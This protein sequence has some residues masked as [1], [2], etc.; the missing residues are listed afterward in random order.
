MVG[1]RVTTGGGG[2]TALVD[3]DGSITYAEL[4]RAVR[5]YA[6]RLDRA[7]VPAG[8]CGLVVADDAIATVVAVLALWWRG[9]VAV[10]VSSMLTPA[11]VSFIAGDCAAGYLHLDDRAARA[12]PAAG[13]LDVPRGGPDRAGPAP[14]E[15]GTP[16]DGTPGEDLA[17]AA[18]QAPADVVLIQYTSGSTGVPKGVR[19]TV[20]GIDAVLAGFAR[21]LDLTPADRV[22]STAKLSFGYGF[23]NS[24]LFPLAAG[25]SAVLRPGPPDVYGVVATVARHRPTVL[26]AV[27]RIYAALLDRAR[28]GDPPDLGSVRLAVSAGE[29]LPGPVCAGFT[30]SFGVPLC[31]GLGATEVLHIVVATRGTEPDSTGT[32]VPGVTLTV[33]DDE[34]RVLPDGAEGR[35]H[36]AGGCVA[37]GYLDRPEAQARTF[38]DGGAYPGDIVRRRPDGAIEYVCRRDDLLNIGGYKVAPV[39]IENAVRGLAGLAQCAVVGSRDHSGLEQAVAYLVPADGTESAALRRAA[40]KAFRAGLPPFKRPVAVEVVDRLPVTSTGKL[41]RFKLRAAGVEPVPVTLRVL[42]AGRPDAP[43]RPDATAADRTDASGRPGG[44]GGGPGRTLVCVPHA[45]GSSGSFTRL[46]GQLP[47]GWRVVAGEADYA[48]GVTLDRAARGWWRAV[49]PYLG[50]GSV[51][52][53]HSLGAALVAAIAEVAGADLAGVRLV[54]AAP[55]LLAGP[56][57]RDLLAEPDDHRLIA[58]LTR[59]GLLPAGTFGPDEIARLLL[60]RFRRDVALLPDGFDLPVTVPV[61]VLLGAEDPLCTPAEVATR[62][63]AD[64]VAG[65]RTVEGGHYFVTTHAAQTAAAL[66]AFFPD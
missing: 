65:C 50:E 42:R 51:L 22:F 7:G 29:H 9:M 26:C 31:N 39:E 54:L 56:V 12:L 66:T 27:P 45:G 20:A 41:A 13:P 24:L 4:Y 49:R 48:D 14:D 58:G 21:L 28:H 64:L 34:G 10:P 38:A 62:L 37:A 16:G 55:P 11:E 23:G 5:G 53:G 2:A 17:P 46:A 19:H 3:A 1:A 6:A 57:L 63:P 43:D 30:E 36:V 18:P 52:L 32:A 35:L 8:A 61:H 40:W 44:G 59:L 25:A 47:P 33:R 60:P 15:D